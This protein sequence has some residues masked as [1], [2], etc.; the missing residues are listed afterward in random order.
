MTTFR[1]ANHPNLETSRVELLVKKFGTIHKR[2]NEVLER[3]LTVHWKTD[4]RLIN[5]GSCFY[6]PDADTFYVKSSCN[7]KQNKINGLIEFDEGGV[8]YLEIERSRIDR[9]YDTVS[10]S[11]RSPVDDF[12]KIKIIPCKSHIAQTGVPTFFTIKN[13][14]DNTRGRLVQNNIEDSH[15]FNIAGNNKQFIAFKVRFW[16]WNQCKKFQFSNRKAAMRF[17]V[18]LSG[19][20]VED[21]TA[22]SCINVQQNPGRGARV[23]TKLPDPGQGPSDLNGNQNWNNVVVHNSQLGQ[24]LLNRPQ[25]MNMV[26][27]QDAGQIMKINIDIPRTFFESLGIEQARIELEAMKREICSIANNRIHD[28][29]RRKVAGNSELLKENNQLKIMIQSLQN[30]ISGSNAQTDFLMKENDRLVTELKQKESTTECQC[31][32]QNRANE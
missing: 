12:N 3:G 25:Q 2:S 19:R 27:F 11:V 9:R 6:R 17:V 8:I 31:R 20:N 7:I 26:N 29:V 18:I 1:D 10:F 5:M 28:A 4:K 13:A 22:Y 24:Q 15:Q 16:C 30:T 32:H 21:I 14:E 23:I